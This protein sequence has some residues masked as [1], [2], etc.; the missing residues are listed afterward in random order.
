MSLPAFNASKRNSIAG[1]SFIKIKDPPATGHTYRSAH[2]SE[3]ADL[4][5]EI[6]KDEN[7]PNGCRV[8]AYIYSKI[9]TRFKNHRETSIKANPPN[10]PIT[11]KSHSGT[12][13]PPKLADPGYPPPAS[14]PT[15]LRKKTSRPARTPAKLKGACVGHKLGTK[16]PHSKL[17]TYKRKLIS[18]HYGQSS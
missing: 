15:S 18:F 3:L 6:I 1:D 4:I 7:K 9:D 16:S 8:K 17:N 10:L 11:Q 5:A 2:L 14:G 13:D 12:G